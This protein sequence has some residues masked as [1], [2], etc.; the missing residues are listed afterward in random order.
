M[1]KEEKVP[2]NPDDFVS[3]REKGYLN[4]IQNAVGKCSLRKFLIEAMVLTLTNQWIV[5]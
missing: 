4:M 5:D 1:S 3:M 2:K